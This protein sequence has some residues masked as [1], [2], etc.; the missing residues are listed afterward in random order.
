MKKQLK[1]FI[2]NL[3]MIIDD[4]EFLLMNQQKEYFFKIETIKMRM[5]FKY[6]IF[7]FRDFIFRIIFY[8]LGLIFQ[9]YLFAQK[10]SF[11]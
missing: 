7:L 11:R 5:F 9:Q 6:Q 10:K 3:K 1:F 2:E 8:V 4:I